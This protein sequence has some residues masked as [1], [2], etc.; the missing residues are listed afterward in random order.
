MTD[1]SRRL[2]LAACALLVMAACA[3]LPDAKLYME[4]ANAAPVRMEGARGR[5]PP[6]KAAAIMAELKRQSGDIDILQKHVALEQEI[7]GGTLSAGNKTVLLQDIGRA[8]E[9][10]AVPEP[11]DRH[12]EDRGVER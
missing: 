7:V 10:P 3:S 12:D 11:T 5:L 6:E 4:G 8:I 1:S 9:E 2:A